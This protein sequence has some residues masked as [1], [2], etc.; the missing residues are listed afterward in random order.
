[1]SRVFT[2]VRM[3]S[4]SEVRVMNHRPRAHT[5]ETPHPVIFFSVFV[6]VHRRGVV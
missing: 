3:D 4:V 5:P 6:G 1:M 2:M